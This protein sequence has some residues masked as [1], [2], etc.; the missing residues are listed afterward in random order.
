MSPPIDLLIRNG[1]LVTASATLQADV[2]IAG[3]RFAAIASPG[4]IET[5][6]DELD[7]TG[8]YVLPG[9]IDGH[10]HFREPGLEYK[11]DFASG[12]RA[13]VRGGVTPLLDMRNT[14]P[15]TD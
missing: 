13:P 4:S 14:K 1:T 12:S 2:A 8:L 3:G 10:V 7:A 15:P 5:A 11:E 9:V 6:T